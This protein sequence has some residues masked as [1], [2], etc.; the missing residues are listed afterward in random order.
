ME[1]EPAF[2]DSFTEGVETALPDSF[3]ALPALR[4]A[5]PGCEFL[6]RLRRHAGIFDEILRVCGGRWAPGC[7]SYLFDGKSYEYCAAMYPK[8]RLLFEAARRLGPGEGVLEVGVYM[9]HSLLIMLM[10]NPRLRITGV[11]ISARYARPAIDVL[12][13]H[14]PHAELTL[15]V[16][17]S[18]GVLPGLPGRFSLMH[19]DGSHN[20]FVMRA[21]F[22]NCRRLAREDAELVTI[23]VNDYLCGK[24]EIDRLVADEEWPGRRLRSLESPGCF[25][26]NLVVSWV[27]VAAA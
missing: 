22:E 26:S 12:R 3:S 1:V 4:E 19:I 14:F 13:R 16:G 7:G 27:R 18:R 23:A 17:D 2:S 11:D 9:G 20:S 21:D 6:A 15:L 25:A 10:A 8:Q 5:H 24:E